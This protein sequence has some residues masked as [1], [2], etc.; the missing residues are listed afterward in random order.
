MTRILLVVLAL[1]VISAVGICAVF[2]HDLSA[3]RARLMGHIF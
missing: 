1:L 3:A 2:A